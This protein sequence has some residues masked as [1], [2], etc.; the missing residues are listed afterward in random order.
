MTAIAEVSK[1]DT[2]E[3][4]AKGVVHFANGE[5]LVRAFANGLLFAYANDTVPA[6]AAIRFEFDGSALTA[7]S[8]DRYRLCVETVELD[9]GINHEGQPAFD[10]LLPRDA[11]KNALAALKSNKRG[12]VM[13]VVDAEARTIEL[14]FYNSTARYETI[15]NTFPTWR[16]LLP[17]VGEEQAH[18]RVGFTPK[19]LADLGKV[20]TGSKVDMVTIKFYKENKP[21]L[22][23][24]L[25]GPLVVLMPV[26]V[27]D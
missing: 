12:K 6:I 11:A 20:Q 4:A 25:D 15:D 3:K 9:L 19:F 23:E 2:R 17:T 22:I 18:D 7:I 10:F 21:T 26:R 5:S 14:R 24:Y 27:S 13:L 1:P 8:T 16:S